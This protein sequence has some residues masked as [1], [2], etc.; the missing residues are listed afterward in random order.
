VNKTPLLPDRL[1]TLDGTVGIR[2]PDHPATLQVIGEVG[3]PLT[4]TS[5]NAA[6]SAT[7]P[8][9]EFDLELLNWSSDEIVYVVEDDEAIVYDSPSTLVRVVGEAIEVLRPGPISESEVD[10]VAG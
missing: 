1:V 7:A 9:E 3:V 5:L 6:G 10:R 4:A 8:I 2:I